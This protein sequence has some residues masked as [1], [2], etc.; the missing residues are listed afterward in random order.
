MPSDGSGEM[1][2]LYRGDEERVCCDDSSERKCGAV[3]HMT[4]MCGDGSGDN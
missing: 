1:L 4:L 3:G 2:E